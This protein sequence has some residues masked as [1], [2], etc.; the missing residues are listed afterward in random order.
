MYSLVLRVGASSGTPV[1]TLGL[2]FK[3]ESKRRFEPK[4]C[5]GGSWFGSIGILLLQA[6]N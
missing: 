4:G 2:L 5:V 6:I 3:I 1:A